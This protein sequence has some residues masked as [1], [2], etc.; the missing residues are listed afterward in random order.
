MNVFKPKTYTKGDINCINYGVKTELANKI[1]EGQQI[2]E[3]EQKNYFFSFNNK[4]IY[5][6][7]DLSM[8][9]QNN[10]SINFFVIFNEFSNKI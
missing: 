9:T 1:N 4:T 8:V 6:I 5:L 2:T 7:K 10:T 3:E